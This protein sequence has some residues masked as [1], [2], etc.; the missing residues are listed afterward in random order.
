MGSGARRAATGAEPRWRRARAC[1]RASEPRG[2]LGQGHGREDRPGCPPQRRRHCP[3][4]GGLTPSG[5]VLLRSSSRCA[6]S[7]PPPCTQARGHGEAVTGARERAERSGSQPRPPAT[8]LP[9]PSFA[10]LSSSSP[11]PS[12]GQAA[13]GPRRKRGG[14]GN[15]ESS[16]G[17]PRA[18]I[19]SSPWTNLFKIIQ[20]RSPKL[21]I[22]LWCLGTLKCS[23][24]C[25]LEIFPEGKL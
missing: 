10:R 13:P 14:K 21:G 22:R 1:E 19:Y 15:V 20:E 6:R 5:L 12:L 25:S 8:P 23:L 16:F 2:Q 11:R 7:A 18:G 9:Q 17:L 4:L 3:Q 24:H